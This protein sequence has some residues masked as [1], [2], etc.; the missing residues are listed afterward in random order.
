MA[1]PDFRF[2]EWSFGKRP[3]EELY[4]MK[5]DPDCVRNLADDPQFAQLKADLWEQLQKELS[6]QGDPRILG[7][8]DIFDFYPNRHIDRQ[9]KLYERPGYEPIKLF[10]D[11][12]GP[13]SE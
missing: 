2:Y 13:K 5:T 9:K 3:Q 8:G 7:N 10:N 1:D 6:D 12:Y 4:D 11:R